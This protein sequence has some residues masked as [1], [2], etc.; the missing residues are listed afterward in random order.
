MDPDMSESVIQVFIKLYRKGYIYRGLR[1][2]NWDPQA[3]TAISNE[4]V[5]Y[6]ELKSKLY[7]VKYKILKSKKDREDPDFI[8]IA[9]TR[10]ETILGDTAVC[11]NPKD[12][13][14][15]H[16]VGRTVVVPATGKGG[17]RVKV[18][19]DEYVDP[20]FGTGI[21]KIT[22]AHDENDYEIGKRHDLDIISVIDENGRISFDKRRDF[23]GKDR[24]EVRKLIVEYL[25][26]KGLLLKEE[27]YVNKV[28]FSERTDVII[29]PRLSLQ[30]FLR[31][32][33]LAKPALDNV[34]N[35]EIRLVPEK[36]INTYRHW[37]ENIRDWCISRQLWWGHRI[38]AWYLPDSDDYVVADTAEEALKQARKKTGN[39]QLQIGD[40]HQDEDVLDT[41]FSSWLWPIS[42][43]DGIRRPH[44]PDFE[45]YYPT[46]DLVTAP[47][48]LFFWVA[49]MIIAGYEFAKEKPFRNV[50][51]TGIVRDK[52]RRKMSKSLGNSPEPLKLIGKYGADGVRVGML[53]CSPAGG[54]LLFDESLTEQGRNFG[55]K[56][57]N[58]F[59]LVKGWTVN[60]SEKQPEA[61]AQ[62]VK[63]FGE[64]LNSTKQKLEDQFGS[65]RLSEALMTV[66][67]LFWDEFSAWYLEIVKPDAGKPLDPQT[68]RKTIEYFEELIILLHPFMP[69]ITE[70]IWQ[71]IRKRQKGESIMMTSW[72]DTGTFDMKCI[73][74]FEKTKE[75]VTQIRTIRKNGRIPQK[76]PLRLIIK[77]DEQQFDTRYL[78]VLKKMSNLS[79]ILFIREKPENAIS[80]IVGTTEYY[81]PFI[82]EIDLVSEKE[83]IR[84]DLEYARGFLK[85]VMKKLGNEQ[86]IKN[87]PEA[88]VAKEKAKQEDAEARIQALEE[89]LASLESK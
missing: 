3:K 67:R 53:L 74:R 4:E 17:R 45:Y 5:I 83:K 61:S 2:V 48:I 66:Y 11:V 58:A 85:S 75:A 40:L 42:V 27:D 18:I 86:F 57:W 87:A 41:W 37:M 62:A 44:N 35:G 82:G 52:Q 38:P 49:R 32:K 50:Y 28:G 89:R 77:D 14:F 47:E 26:G 12:E 51:L 21:L 76:K 9:T 10:P 31:M 79:E 88:V 64:L 20:E 80:F 70:E 24:F 56:I 19:A 33:E 6:K 60:D 13:R 25:K 69:F 34:M 43:F 22:P 36:F 63:W 39:D 46:N 1:M 15:R 72:P 65:Y 73:D 7:Y 59:R 29:E 55:N 68:Y 54:D 71:L 8:T 84:N 81:I 16:L 23:H 78:D 30:W